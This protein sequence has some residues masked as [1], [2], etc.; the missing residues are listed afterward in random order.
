MSFL[1]KIDYPI[2]NIQVPTT[3]KT[4]RFRPFLVKEEKLLLMAKESQTPVDILTAIKQVVTNCSIDD[5]L[6]I[7]SI[8]LFDLEYIFLK[9][10]AVSV[11]NTVKVSFR[12]NNDQKVYDFEIDLNKV[13]LK[14]EEQ[15]DPVIRITD[16]A[17]LVMKYPPASLYDDKEFLELDKDY[18]FELIVRCID[19]IYNEEEVYEAK[20]YKKEDLRNFLEE[21]NVKTFEDIQNFLLKSPKLEH[22]L[23][24]TNSLGESREIV[25][26]SLND[27]FTWR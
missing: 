18:M 6:D 4:F 3:K 27:F 21:L 26:S 7:D 11:D 8:S 25:L 12:D 5:K 16:K 22:K 13:E 17:G 9:L 15:V 14:V 23:K 24:Y 2:H 19:K 20:D 1:P 10:R